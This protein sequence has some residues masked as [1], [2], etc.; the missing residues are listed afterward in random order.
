M[1]VQE[2]WFTIRQIAGEFWDYNSLFPAPRP[3]TPTYLETFLATLRE[4]GYSIFVILGTLPAQGSSDQGSGNGAFYTPQQ[5]SPSSLWQH[6]SAV[7]RDPAPSSG[8][9]WCLPVER[10]PLVRVSVWLLLKGLF[11]LRSSTDG[12]WRRFSPQAQ[13]DSVHV[14]RMHWLTRSCHWPR[15]APIT[16]LILGC[17]LFTRP[18]K[19][20][21]HELTRP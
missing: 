17:E 7:H 21:A 12:L 2:H 20:K 5:V 13:A 1:P 4:Q 10:E 6:I 9:V 14:R 16:C 11:M 19:G 3:L 15:A 18:G 8:C